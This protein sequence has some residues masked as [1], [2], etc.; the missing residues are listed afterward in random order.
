MIQFIN[1]KINI[2]LNVVNRRENGFHDLET[3]FY[4]IGIHNGTYHNPEPFCDILEIVESPAQELTFTGRTIDCPVEKNLVT[5]AVELFHKM[6]AEKRPDIAAKNFSVSLDKYLPDGAGLGGGSSDAS[7]TM[8]ILNGMYGKP[9]DNEELRTAAV[10]LGADCPFFIENRPCFATGIGEI[11]E[12]MTPVLDG[13]WGVLVK[14]PV[15]IVTAEAF[16]NITPGRPAYDLRS[17]YELGPGFWREIVVNDFE[18]S[19][20]S[21]YPVIG[22]LKEQLY[23]HGAI[24]ASMSGTGSAV[25]G[26]F[27]THR[28]ATECVEAMRK[29][30]MY[31]SICRF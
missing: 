31:M 2:G 3:V 22:R 28:D 13:L 5:R 12:P 25:Y 9:F 14:P 7:F 10:T 11:L 15:H 30:D 16:A 19:I 1:A 20:A 8:R 29:P 18:D 6:L 17:L 27:R 24:F 4:P 21:K 26:I 23:T